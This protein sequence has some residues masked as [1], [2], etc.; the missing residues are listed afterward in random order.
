MIEEAACGGSVPLGNASVADEARTRVQ[1][2]DVGSV[3]LVEDEAL[4]AFEAEDILAELGFSDIVVCSSFRAASEAIADRHFPIAVFDLNLNGTMSTP[5]IEEVCERGSRV[6]L[7]TGYEPRVAGVNE[8]SVEHVPK[9]YTPTAL[10]RAVLRALN[11]VP[12]DGS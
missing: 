10:T 4:I 5:L 2:C 12:A 1:P 11:A 6:V 7:T 9:P 8:P 3:L